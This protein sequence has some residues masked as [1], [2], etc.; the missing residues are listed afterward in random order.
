MSSKTRNIVSSF[1]EIRDNLMEFIGENEEVMDRFIALTEE[2]NARL[3]DAKAHIRDIDTPDR[4][5]VGPFVRSKVPT[6][7]VYDPTKV[8]ISV[9][10]LPGVIKALDSKA[11]EKHVQL[12][13]IT[14]VQVNAARTEKYGT[15]RITGPKTIEVLL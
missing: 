15:P 11:I 4:V 13:A 5:S 8:D 3:Y 9:L 10:T 7:T 12:G 6:S 2:Y 1:M 14:P